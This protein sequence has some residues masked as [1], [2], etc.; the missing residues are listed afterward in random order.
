MWIDKGNREIIWPCCHLSGWITG[1]A[2][3]ERLSGISVL[4]LKPTRAYSVREYASIAPSRF[5]LALS[6]LHLP[7]SGFHVFGNVS[8]PQLFDLYPEG[9]IS[10]FR[11]NLVHWTCSQFIYS[12]KQNR[13]SSRSWVNFEGKFCPVSDDFIGYVNYLINFVNKCNSNFVKFINLRK[14][15]ERAFIFALL[16]IY[17]RLCFTKFKLHKRIEFLSISLV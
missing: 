9:I 2:K 1:A 6:S 10:K 15:K 7:P 17:S 5:C 11:F 12:M 8:N 14:S 4:S 13:R 16:A 3:P